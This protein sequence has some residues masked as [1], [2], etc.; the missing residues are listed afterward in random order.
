MNTRVNF[1]GLLLRLA[2]C[3]LLHDCLHAITSCARANHPAIPKRV[4]RFGGENRHGS[5]LAEMEVAHTRDR[6]RTDQWHITGKHQ[7][8]LIALHL[9]AGAH[10]G[11]PGAALL[12]LQHKLHAKR[13]HGLAHALRL[14]ANDYVNIIGR[15][16][17]LRRFDYVRQQRLSANLMQHLSA[18]G[19]QA[20]AFTRSH[21]QNGKVARTGYRRFS[22]ERTYLK[23]REARSAGW[24]ANFARAISSWHSRSV[25]WRA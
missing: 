16:D 3:L 21:N 13:L 6:L 5:F 11:V 22:H 12:R 25:A 17:L 23:A 7:N 15:D 2:Q 10:D 1:A 9:L 4:G 20:R 8:V 18:P 19:F 24:R 14:V